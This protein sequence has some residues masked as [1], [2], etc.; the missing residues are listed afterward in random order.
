VRGEHTVEEARLLDEEAGP[1]GEEA[2]F[3]DEEA[4]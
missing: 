4:G 1:P 3:L 2:R